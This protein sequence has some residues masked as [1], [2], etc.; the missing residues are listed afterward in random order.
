M[1]NSTLFH[2]ADTQQGRLARG[3][4][5]LLIGLQVL[6]VVLVLAGVHLTSRHLRSV[7][8]DNMRSHAQTQTLTKTD[9]LEQN[10]N[11]LHM[12]LRALITDHPEAATD[13]KALRNSLFGL[14]SKL[15]YIR[16]LT[17][18]EADG[19]VLL[20]TQEV[21]EGLLLDLGPLLPAVSP[22]TPDL[23]RFGA[24][25]S[26]RDFARG[27]RLS[28]DAA[29]EPPS[30]GFFPV[31]IVLP[32][33]PQWT[34]VVAINSDY[35]I[36]LA[37]EH[38]GTGHLA[39]RAFLDDGTLL[40]STALED[41][42]GSRTLTQGQRED[43]HLHHVG[44]RSWED[45]QGVLQ[46]SAFRTARNYP[47]FVQAQVSSD[48]I[49]AKWRE[50]TRQLWMISGTTLFVMLLTSSLLT[51]R[52]RR[53]LRREERSLEQNR[54]AASV[55]LYSSDLIIIA[56]SEKNIIAV[57]PAYEKITGYS[58]QEA[59]GNKHWRIRPGTDGASLYNNLWGRLERE[60]SWQGEVT[61]QHK[62]GSLITG[63]LQVNAIQDEAGRVINYVGVFKD[64]SRLRE[65]EA[66]NRKLS[67][68]IEQSPSSIVITTP[69]AII[70]YANPRFL[71]SSG[72]S[73]E[74]V[75]G[76]NPRILQSGQTPRSTYVDLWTRISA[77]KVW[78][79]EFINRRKDGTIYYERSTISP[80]MDTKGRLTGYL[81]V[82]H[83][84]TSEKEAERNLRLAA[85]VIANTAECVLICDADGFI[86]EVNPAFTRL[87]GYS[88][89]DVLGRPSSMLAAENRNDETRAAMYATL[90]T[91]GVWQGEFWNRRKDGS[92]Y[93]V[94][95]SV[96]L[97][98]DDDGHITH[99]IS[100]FSDITDIKQR[101]ES[102]QKQA[103][104]DPLTGLANRA[105]LQERLEQAIVR[106]RRQNQWC[107]VC[108]MDLDGFKQVNDT[109]G[110]KAGDD[111]L[112]IIA[113]RLKNAVRG[114]DT[115][116]RIGGDEFVIILSSLGSMDECDRVATRIL[117]ALAAPVPLGRHEAC[118]TGSMGITVYPL[119]S[120]NAEQ[121]LRH[122]D[123]AMYQAKQ[124]GRN[125][126]V[127]S[128]KI[129]CDGPAQPEGEASG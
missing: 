102:L 62:D 114:H 53:S 72:Y 57:N 79:G 13:A 42:P 107:A 128:N 120:G 99:Y 104:F 5:K 33:A 20:S 14:Q 111:L 11:L 9:R 71:S 26:G 103:H 60:S 44:V 48:V 119:D 95:S 66:T 49:L 85:S 7:A 3:S 17:V 94:S 56:D 29:G 69:E 113:Q 22:H 65:S 78:H 74:E 67:L 64:L 80:V 87:T 70:E 75:L 30:I 37:P 46:L 90:K 58:A 81:G 84:I 43:I 125:R 121:L 82:K 35:F 36:N 88:R 8:L 10:L 100:V 86:I 25:W 123:H 63:W 98:R 101:Q 55:F 39:F 24:P 92:L 38:G 115:V 89:E 59:L 45:A 109:L 91:E 127:V 21:N 28:P 77:G 76:A 47:W 41:R 54:L 73:E 2:L 18:L 116:A 16:S 108:F 6:L 32:E 106:A 1:S 4:V 15:H 50:D 105:L 19:Q 96:N 23:L 129:Q 124:S 34:L 12:H 117:Q 31:T 110:H 27:K 68:A 40:F 93:V 61:E 83:D 118:V 51:A 52:A 126:Y 122:A 97:L 112:I